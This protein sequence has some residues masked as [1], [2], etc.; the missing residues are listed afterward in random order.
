LSKP[1]PVLV[2]AAVI[3][4]A[5]GRF[6][7]ARRP[8]GK[9]YA[10]YWEFPGGKAERGETLPDAL[11][12]ELHEE[13]G[14]E[15]TRAYP[16][17][18]QRYVYPHAHVQLHFFRV[19]GWRGEP[20]SKEDQELVWAGLRDLGVAPLLPANA[21][22]LRAL[23]LPDRLGITCASLAGEAP[24]LRQLD[25][26][27]A[28][29][30]GM[31]MVREKSMAR[32]ALGRFAHEVVAR[33]HAAGALALIN[34]EAQLA[35]QCGADGVHL[36]ASVLMQTRARPA[37]AL[38]GASCHDA[39]E[40]AKAQALGVDYAVLGPVLPTLSHPGQ[41][42]LGW[43]RFAALAAGCTVPVYAI[44]GMET[45]HLER[46]WQAGAHGVAMMRAAWA[47]A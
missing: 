8:G 10:G 21:P 26:A 41:P 37:L 22:V 3:Q 43:E 44:G 25:A 29:G 15:V 39:G 47:S 24:F 23:A 16:W 38:C 18:V 13:L 19:L 14:I 42:A 28:R 2:A 33:C 31:V 36:P 1:D 45:R 7:L 27:L 40:L 34:G 17:L 6:L 35:A 5:D 30:L 32:E 11:A 9:V 46:A 4:R 20:H 12:R